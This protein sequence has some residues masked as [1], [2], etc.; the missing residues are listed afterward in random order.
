MIWKSQYPYTHLYCDYL[1]WC[2]K[3]KLWYKGET[4]YF[5]Y[6]IENS[7]FSSFVY[8]SIRNVD[9]MW[10]WM[11][12]KKLQ[13]NNCHLWQGN[14]DNFYES[15]LCH[16]SPVNISWISIAVQNI[17]YQFIWKCNLSIVGPFTWNSKDNWM[18]LEWIV[19]LSNLSGLHNKMK[20][21][22]QIT[23]KQIEQ[24]RIQKH[25][26]HYTW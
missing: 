21:K 5:S 19:I 23:M 6:I 12:K 17:H 24:F 9:K 1:F 13:K 7:T 18:A 14:N 10:S 25:M 20:M 11:N 4:F 16:Y 15:N 8:T 3:M 2:M 26:S 22:I